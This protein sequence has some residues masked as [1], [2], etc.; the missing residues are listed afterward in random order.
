MGFFFSSKPAGPERRK[1]A[2]TET[3]IPAWIDVGGGAPLVACTA[4]D[5]SEG[6]ARLAV[7]DSA[8]LPGNLAVSLSPDGQGGRRCRV[9]WR[10]ERQIG[11]EY[12]SI[13][14]YL[15]P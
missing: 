14:H 5:T 4:L 11:V 13:A 10:S 9:A 1:H 3:N 8:S 7:P 6:G 12:L 15:L 2:R